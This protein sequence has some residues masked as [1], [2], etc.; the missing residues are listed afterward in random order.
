MSKVKNACV[1]VPL[2]FLVAGS[3]AVRA[4]SEEV[5]ELLS[6]RPPVEVRP[7]APEP[8]DKP[9]FAD[10]QGRL[11]VMIDAEH[12]YLKS[13]RFPG[14]FDGASA[15]SIDRY[16]ILEGLGSSEL[17]DEVIDIQ[18]RPDA[19]VPH[20]IVDC[21]NRTL[22]IAVRKIYQFDPDHDEVIKTVEIESRAEKLMTVVSV[23]VLSDA[24]RQGGYYYQYLTHTHG[25]HLSVSDVFHW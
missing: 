25:R 21:L 3:C 11:E 22:A 24:S 8:E 4:Q 16:I 5:R 2:G 18:H 14:L 7:P 9:T 1:L 23:S 12:G 20:V 17:E 13:L 15:R 19:E 10:P 6:N